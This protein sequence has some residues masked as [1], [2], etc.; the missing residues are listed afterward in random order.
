MDDETT[1]EPG[2]VS[3][4]HDSKPI[5]DTTDFISTI[6]QE[7]QAKP[8]MQGISSMD[9]LMKKLD[10]AQSLI[11]KR[12]AG[13]PHAEASQEEWNNFY[14]LAGRPKDVGEYSF[15]E[16]ESENDSEDIKNFNTELKQIFHNN[17]LSKKQ[18]ESFKKDYDS[19]IQKSLE[20]SNIESD[21]INKDFDSL[22]QDHFGQNEATILQTG[23]EMI[24]T[25][26][27]ES[28]KP[29]IKDLDNKSLLILSSIMDSVKKQYINEDSTVLKGGGIDPQSSA[30]ILRKEA[31]DLM[32]SDAYRN[33]M[34]ND[35]DNTVQ[36]VNGLYEQ[37]GAISRK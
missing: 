13:I 1:L 15:G 6:P 12:P 23:K 9:S 22:V 14:D 10:G 30:N 20:S 3:T 8:Y 16:S 31:Q 4:G 36:K 21:N 33:T 29:F 24:N 27:Q 28:L 18:G 37:I 26:T 5:E 2:S 32:K 11:G 35:H 19:L 7:Y 17:G 25:H 34:N